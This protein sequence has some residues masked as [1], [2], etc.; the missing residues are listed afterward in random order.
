MTQKSKFINVL[1]ILSSLLGYLEWSGDSSTFLFQAEWDV[2]TGLFNNPQAMI[3][4]FILIPL[5][6]QALLLITLF[7]KKPSRILTYSS[8]ACMSLLLVFMFG[9]GLLSQNYKITLSTVPFLVMIFAAIRH[10]RRQRMG[11]KTRAM[12]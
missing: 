1:V 11:S 8:I 3:H 6:G 7:Q 10:H 12:V 9:I 2:I 5:A 4:P